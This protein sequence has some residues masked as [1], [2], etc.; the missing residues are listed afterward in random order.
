MQIMQETWYYSKTTLAW[1][2]VSG[3]FSMA[4]KLVQF[5]IVHT[6]SPSATAFGGNF[7]K[8]ALMFLTLCLPFL[9]T[10]PNP[11]MPYIGW[12]WAAL[13]LNIY[14]FSH[15]SYLQIQAKKQ[16]AAAV[17]KEMNDEEEDS[18][19]EEDPSSE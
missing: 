19:D 14:A 10:K 3:G 9:Q 17:H 5:N 4:Y 18:S 11:P 8:A 6:L 2:F 12:E 16:A 15:Y 7:N 13:I 1:I